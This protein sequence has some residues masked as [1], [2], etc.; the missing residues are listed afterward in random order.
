MLEIYEKNMV[1]CENKNIIFLY[2]FLI[3]QFSIG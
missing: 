1:V 2:I 3:L